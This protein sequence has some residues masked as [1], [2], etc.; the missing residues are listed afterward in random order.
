MTDRRHAK[1]RGEDRAVTSMVS[2]TLEAGI[3][4]LFIG[5]VTTGLYA[6]IVPDYRSATAAEV[7]ER[8]VVTAGN[9]IEGAVPPNAERVHVETRVDLPATIR[10]ER[11]RIVAAGRDGESHATP[12]G[13]GGLRIELDHPHPAVDGSYALALPDH[14]VD[15]R[16][17]WSGGTGRVVV[18]TASDGNGL[19]VTLEDDG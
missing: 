19:V 8:T 15:V 5:V 9:E 10:S 7:G 12:T 4:V 1:P 14:V 6:G 11:Y 13:A 18:R 17:E 2:K 16:G 3:V